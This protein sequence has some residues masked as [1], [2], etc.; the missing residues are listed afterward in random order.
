[1]PTDAVA[2]IMNDELL[3]TYDIAKLQVENQ[4][5]RRYGLQGMTMFQM[6]RSL[7]RV[8]EVSNDI[9]YAYEDDRIHENFTVRTNVGDP[10]AGNDASVTIAATDVDANN[11]YY[12]RVG[13]IVTIPDNEVQALIAAIDVT[14][15]TAPV[16][17]LRPVATASNIGALTAGDTISITNGAFAAGTGSP[18]PAQRGA[19]KRTFQA[20]IFKEKVAA[21]GP[22]LAKEYWYEIYDDGGNAQGW[23]NSAIGDA[24]YRMALKEDGAYYFGQ[25]NTNAALVAPTGDGAGN[26][27]KTTKG[28][29][30]WI[31]DIGNTQAYAP[32]TWAITDMD[33]IDLY[34]T[35]QGVTSEYVMFLMGQ[36]LSHEVEN[37]LV[38]YL[39][40]TDV[41]FTRMVNNVFSGDQATA[42]EVNFSQFKKS[43]R[44]YLMK[45][46][47][48][49]SNI[50]TFGADGYDM[51]QYG[52]LLPLSK[53]KDPTSGER[54]DNISTRYVGM[55]G[56]NRMHEVYPISGA[57][58]KPYVTDVDKF[59]FH[60]R[61]HHGL[62]AMKVNQMTL[63]DP[64]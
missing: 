20:Q 9:W 42:V 55:G 51:N 14:T 48:N 47:E 39:K 10:G 44:T 52:M 54:M 25:Q 7:G 50:K 4:L 58:V 49:F 13:D 41:D 12:P 35:Q 31:R 59:E 5:F 60:I 26:T 27:I 37:A 3:S 17:T 45:C 23:Y 2:K 57:K 38:D 19:T 56:Y 8:K 11:N 43:N 40:N 1:M 63:L 53:V 36:R 64:S 62:Q 32:G 24:E 29:I 18:E 61:C 21:E 16:L 33:E 15:P 46:M 34:L 30:P 22:Q 28:I 6:M